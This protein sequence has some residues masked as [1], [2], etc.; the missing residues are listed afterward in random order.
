MHHITHQEEEVAA[1]LWMQTSDPRFPVDLKRCVDK[2]FAKP[3]HP[4]E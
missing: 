4:V 1:A 3:L 2:L